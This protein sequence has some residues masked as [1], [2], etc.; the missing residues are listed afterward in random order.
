M[1][2]ARLSDKRKTGGRLAAR[3]RVET[4]SKQVVG[5]HLNDAGSRNVQGHLRNNNSR[6]NGKGR[7]EG[8]RTRVM[9]VQ[10]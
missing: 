3:Y 6:G 10:G 2:N 4:G 1:K 9:K 8:R 5:L 7:S